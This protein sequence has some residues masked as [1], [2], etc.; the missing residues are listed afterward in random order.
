MIRTSI[1]CDRC[2]CS[3]S[4]HNIV[5]KYLIIDFA[6]ENSWSVGKYHLCPDCRKNGKNK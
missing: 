6:R 5:P 2:G 1:I 4:L 3:F